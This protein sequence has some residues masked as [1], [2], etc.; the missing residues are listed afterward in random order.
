LTGV[1]IEQLTAEEISRFDK[2]CQEWLELAR[3]TERVDRAKTEDAIK[4]LYK[5]LKHPAPVIFWCQSPWQMWMMPAIMQV[6]LRC[7]RL[8]ELKDGLASTAESELW[9]SLWAEIGSQFSFRHYAHFKS[10][11]ARRQKDFSPEFED[12]Y[13]SIARPDSTNSL[14]IL[15]S[16][17]EGKFPGLLN[18]CFSKEVAPFI[19]NKF[20][21]QFRS[22]LNRTAGLR[23]ARELIG[24]SIP[25]AELLL[26][27]H[28][29]FPL[30]DHSL[31]AQLY[32]QK[33]FNL[34]NTDIEKC[35][36]LDS[37]GRVVNWWW[38]P[39]SS[40][41]FPVEEFALQFPD[42]QAPE[43]ATELAVWCRLARS[44]TAFSFCREVC[45]VCERPVEI[46]FD[47]ASRL[48]SEKGPAVVFSDGFQVYSW[49]G[50]TVPK[51]VAE[52][53]DDTMLAAIQLESNAEVR[54]VM[55]E[56]YGAGRFIS[57]MSAQIIDSDRY[58]TLY[59]YH[60]NE[61]ESLVMVK[62]VNRTAE[63]NGTFKEYFLRVPPD[64]RTARAAVAW[65]FGMEPDEYDPGVET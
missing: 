45:F 16:S 28:L 40:V 25:M 15:S 24:M 65:T 46:H 43:L 63:P 22:R 27:Q 29:N 51:H 57:K 26:G 35:E 61:D 23:I 1:R 59:R 33:F 49:N 52:T 10:F 13:E 12:L 4:D 48:H 58:G 14:S 19:R 38:G 31:S 34:L 18:A 56:R 5:Q 3:S 37:L 42:C 8:W 50:V 2:T 21:S 60:M 55:V 36:H 6:M 64:I 20:D 11:C 32:R 54:R 17:P 7:T 9:R 41:W 30:Q 39:W 62:I 44:A 53:P 47:D